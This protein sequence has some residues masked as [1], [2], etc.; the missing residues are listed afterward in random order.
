MECPFKSW[1]NSKI[2]LNALMASI[3]FCPCLKHFT[4]DCRKGYTKQKENEEN[5]ARVAKR[6]FFFIS[7]NISCMHMESMVVEASYN[8]FGCCEMI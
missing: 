3:L 6:N 4:L 7:L 2:K 8:P 1:L 5:L